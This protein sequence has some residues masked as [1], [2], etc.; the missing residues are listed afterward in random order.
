MVKIVIYLI[1]LLKELND[2][3]HV[4]IFR[5]VPGIEQALNNITIDTMLM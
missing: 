1:E 3:R 2:L 4:K 5:T